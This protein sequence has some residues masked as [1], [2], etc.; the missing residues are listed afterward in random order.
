MDYGYIL[1]RAW[2]ITWRYRVL[3]LFGLLSGLRYSSQSTINTK[4]TLPPDIQRRI[5]EFTSSP[6]FVLIVVALS[7]LA[8]LIGLALALLNALG[9]AALV[10]QVN[11]IED[12][13]RPAVGLGWE[14]GRRHAWRV[15]LI[16][17]LLGL[18]ALVTMMTG[19]IP[20]FLN[21]FSSGVFAGTA[22]RT[23]PSTLFACFFPS[24][25]LSLLLV[26]PLS[27]IRPL[28][29]RACVLEDRSV[30][31]SLTRGWEVLRVDLG[32][33]VLFCLLLLGIGIALLA[34][35]GAPMCLLATAFVAPVAFLPTASAAGMAWL[36]GAGFLLWLVE[37]AINSVTA[38]FFSSCWTIAYRDLTGLGQTG[39]TPDGMG[40]G[41]GG[42][43][44]GL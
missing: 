41:S 33:I 42:F 4:H 25:C 20:L 40:G 9:Q 44:L 1:Q 8:L 13:D 10:D 12:G 23:A 7:L 24:L 34:V 11:R 37:M 21:L 28:A 29:V 39:S 3:W 43:S 2:K 38:T 36:C 30:W 31:Q 17:L 5:V 15:F 6:H 32:W 19:L 16:T 26:I 27:I 18:P 35:V 22:S 14:A